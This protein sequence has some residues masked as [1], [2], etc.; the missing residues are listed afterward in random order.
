MPHADTERAY[1]TRTQ[2]E[3]A[4]RAHRERMPHAHTERAC[5][6]RT[7][8]WYAPPTRDISTILDSR[9]EQTS[10]VHEQE[11]VMTCPLESMMT[12]TTS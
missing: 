12:R 1:H 11:P 7:Q 2:R 8:S 3:H 6:T 9:A 10:G 4:T 5:H